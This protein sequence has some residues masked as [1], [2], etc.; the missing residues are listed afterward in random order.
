MDR[1]TAR[2]VSDRIQQI[3]REAATNDPILKDYTIS[4][5]GGRF[6][7]TS[8]RTKLNIVHKNPLPVA[9]VT[10]NI[11]FNNE[12]ISPQLLAAGLAPAGTPIISP[13]GRRGTIIEARRVNY[14]Y[15]EEETG[16]QWVC[17]FGAVWLDTSRSPQ[18]AAAK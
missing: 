6:D 10:G 13:S 17:N 4:V 5:G 7:L 15:V 14:L 18:P 2:V 11:V 1:N 8:L 12:T 16:K 3:I 9:L